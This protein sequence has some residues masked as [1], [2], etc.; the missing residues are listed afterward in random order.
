MPKFLLWLA[1]LFISL[2][3][4]GA[5][6]SISSI[7][8]LAGPVGSQVTIT[9]GGF[10]TVAANN[11][12]FFGTVKAVVSQANATQLVVIVPTGASY[13]QI[14]VTD[15]INGTTATSRSAFAI[16]FPSKDPLSAATFETISSISTGYVNK[17]LVKDLDGDGRPEIIIPANNGIVTIYNNQGNADSL[18]AKTFP[19][20]FNITGSRSANSIKIEDIDN[21]GRPDIIV[22]TD[23]GPISVFKNISSPGNLTAASFARVDLP[24]TTSYGIALYLGDM[25]GDGRP[26]IISIVGSNLVIY[27]NN[28]T[29]AAPLSSTSFTSA[30]TIPINVEGVEDLILNDF[31]GDGRAEIIYAASGK[32]C[33]IQTLASTPGV[34]GTFT[35][36]DL[37]AIGNDLHIASA[38]MDSD[39]KPELLITSQSNKSLYVYQNLASPGALSTASF[40]LKAKIYCGNAPADLRVA[41]LDGDGKPDIASTSDGA[42]FFLFK[43]IY[44][45]GNPAAA[46]LAP[47]II[48]DPGASAYQLNIA[49][50]N[51]DGRPD[52]TF[53]ATNVIYLLKNKPTAIPVF[54]S[55]S[56]LMAAGG[57]T[58]TITGKNFGTDI[59]NVKV[60][61]DTRQARVTSV[62]DNSIQV[63][64]PAG[65]MHARIGVFVL[66]EKRSAWSALAFKT[67]FSKPSDIGKQDY[68]MALKISLPKNS[69]S[70]LFGDLDGD[71]FLDMV[72]IKDYTG[73]AIIPHSG[74]NGH[75]DCT[76]YAATPIIYPNILN[77]SY[78]VVKIQDVNNDGRPDLLL[79]TDG[80]YGFYYCLN[81]SVKGSISFAPPVKNNAPSG[82]SNGKIVAVE[83]IDG[84]GRPDFVSANG[85]FRNIIN[86]NPTATIA[87][88]KYSFASQIMS[89]FD[90]DGDGRPD[91]ILQNAA[92]IRNANRPGAIVDSL[93]IG[94]R[95][96]DNQ[97]F[98]QL[99][100]TDFDND[101]KTDFISQ[102]SAYKNISTLGNLS[103]QKSAN[104]TNA[105]MVAD[106]N[107]DGLPEMITE[108]PGNFIG[109]DPD[110]AYVYQNRAA[111]GQIPL[112]KGRVSFP[113]NFKSDQAIYYT[114]VISSAEDL[115]NDNKPDIT[116]F[117]SFDY[118]V[119][120]FENSMDNAEGDAPPSITGVSQTTAAI[121]T[122]LKI[123][124]NNFSPGRTTVFLGNTKAAI[125]SISSTSITINVP[126]GAISSQL[127]VTDTLTKLKAVYPL[128]TGIK[129]G[130]GT[131]ADFTAASFQ[132]PVNLFKLPESTSMLNYVDLNGDGVNEF[133]INSGTIYASSSK[134]QYNNAT[135][136]T[137]ILDV[138][139]PAYSWG[140]QQVADLDGDGKLD[141][142]YQ[143][144]TSYRTGIGVLANT[145]NASC[146]INFLRSTLGVASGV[147][148]QIALADINGDG[149]PDMIAQDNAVH[150]KIAIYLNTSKRG[151]ISFSPFTKILIDNPNLY[152]E[153]WKI[154]LKDF[155][156]DGK[157][158]LLIGQDTFLQIF[159]NNTATGSATVSFDAPLSITE[160]VSNFAVEDLTGDGKPDIVV[161][162]ATAIDVFKNTSVPGVINASSLSAKVN[163][164]TTPAQSYFYNVKINDMD[165][166]GRPDIISGLDSKTITI[167]R[168]KVTAN[169]IDNTSFQQRNNYTIAKNFGSFHIIDYNFDGRPDMVL[170]AQSGVN[171][172]DVMLNNI[173][174]SG[175][176]ILASPVQANYQ[177]VAPAIAVDG[178]INILNTT[179][180][181]IASAQVAI[182]T[183]YSNGQD[184]LSLTTSTNNGNI[185]AAFN[186]GTGVLTLASAGASNAQWISALKNLKFNTTSPAAGNRL[187]T[188]T[189]TAGSIQSPSAARLISITALP[190]PV[191]ASFSPTIATTGD[192]VTLT[193]TNFSGATGIGFGGVSAKSFTVNPD[194]TVSAIVGAGGNGNVSITTQ[195]GIGSLAGFVFIDAPVINAGNSIIFPGSSVVLV[196]ANTSGLPVQWAKDGID[197]TGAQSGSL[198][199]NSP[200]N[201]T[202]KLI[203]NGRTVSSAP[204]T[205][206]NYFSPPANNFAL[207]VNSATC[208]GTANGSITI[209]ATQNFAYTAVVTGS[210]AA[211]T[212]TFTNTLA[213]NSLPAGT[214]NICFTV[215]GQPG[216]QQCFTAV[217][218]EPKD[219]ALYSAVNTQN[220]TV[221]LT[222]EGSDR[223]LLTL[224]GV[225]TTVSSSNV[226]LNLRKGRNIL[227]VATDKSCQGLLQKEINIAEDLIA[228]PNPFSNTLYINIG[229][230]NSLPTDVGLYSLSGNKIFSKQYNNAGTVQI[231]VS[232]L[233]MGIYLVK[234][235]TGG[236]EKTYK[237]IKK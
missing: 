26:D 84:D 174:N 172:V 173:Q 223:Y 41:D 43:N 25:D 107:G 97:Y 112:Y 202:V 213:I 222:L 154:I 89:V 24:V 141:I 217:I 229:I 101:G 228:Y 93:F 16:T 224:N 136:Y 158:D 49:D 1:F 15:I 176:Q 193:G 122:S 22:G 195:Y 94:T 210:A 201:Y 74:K 160:P 140:A 121:N 188:F 124:G 170:V 103:F 142:I 66:S 100:T 126:P 99:F 70:P 3:T 2:N 95:L 233:D 157:P 237:V 27:K 191:I 182:S 48:C 177:A 185:T 96:L 137:K 54:N 19:K 71:G 14:T 120:I 153:L 59:T 234:V 164:A 68:K 215:A 51:G 183:N 162:T 145:S 168:N 83:D 207:A 33:V 114:S 199:I 128:T 32:T 104:F 118:N 138:P 72:Y 47:P 150:N 102:N 235:V 219:L 175:L 123:D 109:S 196:A 111:T 116:F 42:P 50:L 194:N 67:T 78:L 187:I 139:V 129:F 179:A 197:I 163:I 165:G 171:D 39:G 125:Q 133:L 147:S 119:F 221:A 63:V 28:I 64:V 18:N 37:F 152:S 113:F 220:N 212:Y 208:K 190:V 192:I 23:L 184:V 21:D 35:K 88:Q 214:Y 181:N 57:S 117:D 155:D 91:L 204:R 218:T 40:N 166:D 144:G 131:G 4:L 200:G 211:Q 11:V 8:P 134:D 232:S 151:S 105:R 186:A 10:N 45:A 56:P 203:V 216:Y 132:A 36:T 231:D 61:F 148:S 31:D 180:G 73:L 161:N 87:S 127:S 205:V 7:S 130:D 149:K 65:A 169:T 209:T 230:N 108:Q 60:Y 92:S 79:N 143:D 90:A 46:W 146:G 85:V 34:M 159:R 81:T 13:S 198:T 115:N 5:I 29:T 53:I 30:A 236:T 62:T 98:D 135:G 167:Y 58:I 12:V 156:G 44:D 38:D 80:F 20:Q 225:T 227:T 106:L 110:T 86:E 69:Q 82:N 75:I 52:I 189:A 6:T 9:G 55:F 77:G 17:Q 206:S 226:T 178:D 76:T